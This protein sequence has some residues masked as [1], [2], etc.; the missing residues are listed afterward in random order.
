METL[1][2]V[3]VPGL[4]FLIGRE[5][6][7][8]GLSPSA[9]GPGSQAGEVEF[10]GSLQ[11]LYRA[12]LHLR[13]ADRVLVRLGQFY[14]SAFPEL[15]RKAGRLPW[16]KYLGPGRPVA[17]RVD[18]RTS[19]LYHE[20]AVAERLAGAIADRLG[21]PPAVVKVQESADTD[22]PQL[23]FARLENNLCAIGVDSS[24]APMH[25]RGYRLVSAKAPLRETLACAIVMASEWDAAS[26][27][28]DPFC[29]S[30]TIAI[31]AALLARK[32]PP[33]LSRPFAFMRWPGFNS[34]SWEALLADARKG[35]APTTSKI[36]ASDRDAGA[37]LAAESNAA[38]A[39][40]A[41]SVEFS[42][43]A[44][45]AIEPPPVPGWVVTNPP[46]GVRLSKSNDLR[47]LYAQ[48]GKILAAKCAGWRVTML[49]NTMQLI[50]STGLRFEPGV[51]TMNGGL[52]VRLWTC[53]HVSGRSRRH[54]A[55]KMTPPA[56]PSFSRADSRS[57]VQ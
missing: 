48:L 11:D 22:L 39:G 18:C 12:N 24:G 55:A 40:V 47:N 57:N 33:G 10:Q 20:G 15:R 2:A 38:R 16:E 36:M 54:P 46:Y 32:I 17:F 5:L 4:E 7:G 25:R 30:G 26:P 49:C 21:T 19:R 42:R 1:F 50:R 23:I 8:L 27:L 9:P 35:I 53:P 31:E 44:V 56:P 34:G 6:E 14:A 3:C 43:K 29:G 51:S 13:C 37:I 52:R 41:E 28:L 45:S